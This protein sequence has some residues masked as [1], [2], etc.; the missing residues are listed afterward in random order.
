MSRETHLICHECQQKAIDT[1]ESQ[2]RALGLAVDLTSSGALMSNM[3]RDDHTMNRTLYCKQPTVTPVSALGGFIA[4]SGR[5]PS[6]C[7][8][9]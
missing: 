1:G 3:Q 2:E 4:A 5:I 8:S 6:D 7:G 9:H